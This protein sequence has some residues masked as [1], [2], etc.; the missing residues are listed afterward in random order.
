M[1]IYS[2]R[3]TEPQRRCLHTQKTHSSNYK[4]RKRKGSKTIKGS[5]VRVS[6]SK[7]KVDKLKSLR[8]ENIQFLTKL[9]FKVNVKR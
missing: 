5:A 3:Y 2:N 6:T 1:I 4:E 7:S 8:K 9:G